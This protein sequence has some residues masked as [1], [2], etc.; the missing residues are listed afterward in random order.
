MALSFIQLHKTQNLGIIC[1]AAVRFCVEM[2]RPQLAADRRD[3]AR[4]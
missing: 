1:L 4:Q 3:A 2:S